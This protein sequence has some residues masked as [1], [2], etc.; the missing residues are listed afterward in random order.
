M[1]T[2]INQML[3]LAKNDDGAAKEIMSPVSLSEITESCVLPFESVCFEKGLSL[4]YDIQPDI[5]I[6]GSASSLKQLLMI[7]LDNAAKYAGDNG[8]IRLVLRSDGDKATL[9]VNNTGEPIPAE[10]LRHIF[11]RFYRVDQSRAREKA[12]TALDLRLQK[13]LSTLTER[14][15][16]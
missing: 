13:P 7:L 14:A 16:R 9:S 4:Y 8:T 3:Y 12:G 2:L 11:E 10:K 15:Y 6:V 1:T 5:S